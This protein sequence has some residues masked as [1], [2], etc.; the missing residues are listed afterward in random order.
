MGPVTP[1]TAQTVILARITTHMMPTATIHLPHGPFLPQI[2][3]RLAL[4]SPLP[5]RVAD[6][7]L[8]KNAMRSLQVPSLPHNLP[9]RLAHRTV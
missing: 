8:L 2:Q 1:P 3:T 4:Y 5:H 9:D 6:S 7:F